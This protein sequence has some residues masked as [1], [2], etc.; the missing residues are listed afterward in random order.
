VN[1]RNRTLNVK[2]INRLSK[3]ET[4]GN[5]KMKEDRV[6]IKREQQKGANKREK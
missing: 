5:K 4:K 1:N 3:M 6:R 2:N